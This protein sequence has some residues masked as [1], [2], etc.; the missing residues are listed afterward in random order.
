MNLVSW[1]CVCSL[2]QETKAASMTRT[3]SL[4]LPSQHNLGRFGGYHLSLSA[5]LRRCKCNVPSN[6]TA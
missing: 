4:S 2:T 1:R 3:A 5:P 6:K